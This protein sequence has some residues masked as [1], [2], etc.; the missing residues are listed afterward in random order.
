MRRLEGRDVEFH[1]L[2][3]FCAVATEGNFTRAAGRQN[4]AQPS[5]SQQILKLEDEL[6][7]RLFDRFARSA[8]LTPFG[9]T[10]LPRAEAIL[11]QAGDART[12]ILEMA[13]SEKGEVAL[14]VIPTV[15]PYLLPPVLCRF[16]REH[17]AVTVSVV[18]EVT[19]VLLERLHA[20]RLDL[21]LLALP[22]QGA[23]LVSEELIREALFTVV[24]QN[25]RLASRRSLD[26]REIRDEPFL[27]LKEGHCFRENTIQ[28][29]RHSRV[30]PNV[31]FE[32]GQFSS[33]LALV[34][35]G[36][37]LS[38][39]P[40]MAV[41]PRPGCKFIR[42][43]D[44]RSRRSVGVVYLRSHFAT[45]A[46]RALLDHLRRMCLKR[47]HGASRRSGASPISGLAGFSP[48]SIESA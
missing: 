16:A 15:G 29:C 37:G 11:R 10:F 23:E 42:V 36:V 31:V 14:G 38:I 8:R 44:K 45:R 13:G 47:K 26:L 40:A 28:A 43:R 18:E 34:S 30:Q 9:R 19:P 2:R 22:V 20:G 12:E 25:H 32:T 33:I 41:E 35:A 3:Y 7:A 27:L 6:G 24:P 21:A 1:Q 46:H 17:P 48:R 4:V 5:L 39:V